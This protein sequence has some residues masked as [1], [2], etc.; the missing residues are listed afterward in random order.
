ME[1]TTPTIIV[2]PDLPPSHI[3][4]YAPFTPRTYSCCQCEHT[5]HEL[6]FVQG[7][8]VTSCPH[9]HDPRACIPSY[10][11]GAHGCQVWDHLGQPAPKLRIPAVFL[12]STCKIEHSVYEIMTQLTVTC[13]CGAPYLEAVYDQFG[14]I[15]LWPRGDSSLDNLTDFKKVAEARRR[16][17]ELGAMPWVEQGES[18]QEYFDAQSPVKFLDEV[19]VI[20]Q[21][22]KRPKDGRQELDI[23]IEMLPSPSLSPSLSPSPSPP[24]PEGTESLEGMKRLLRGTGFE[25][26]SANLMKEIMSAKH[27]RGWSQVS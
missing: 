1:T 15:L 23:A 6:I 13:R 25:L 9:R 3:T 14:T 18:L 2:K 17:L 19:D 24:P 7:K 16:L 5:G 26:V 20:K 4:I 12:C 27:S 10:N 22:I 21:A 8:A 11:G